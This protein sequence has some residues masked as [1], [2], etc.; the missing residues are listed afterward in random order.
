MIQWSGQKVH[1][2]G[3]CNFRTVYEKTTKFS[4][5]SFLDG[6]T[7]LTKFQQNPWGSGENV[8]EIWSISHGMTHK[9]FIASLKLVSAIFYQIFIFAQNDNPLKTIKCFL[10]HL[11]SSFGSGY[12]QIFVVFSLPFHIFQIQKDKWRW[13]DLC[14]ELTCINL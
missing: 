3:C 4:G 12:T 13:N 8:S 5:F 14:H 1:S 10:F 7:Y 2:L 11:K 6:Y 9:A